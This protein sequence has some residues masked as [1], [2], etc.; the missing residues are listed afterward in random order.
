MFEN[1]PVERGA[2]QCEVLDGDAKKSEVEDV[3]CPIERLRS[4]L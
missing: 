2:A 4:A 3:N 1:R